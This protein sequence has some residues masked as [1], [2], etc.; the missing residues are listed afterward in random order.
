MDDR[1]RRY[2]DDEDVDLESITQMQIFGKLA[3]SDSIV[4][5][6]EVEANAVDDED[7]Y[8]M[9]EWSEENRL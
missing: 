5:P 8:R 2:Y 9:R 7:V 4:T 3:P 1:S 6:E